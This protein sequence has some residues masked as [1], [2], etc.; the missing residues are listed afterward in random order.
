MHRKHN[1]KAPCHATIKSTMHQTYLQSIIYGK[2]TKNQKLHVQYQD[3]KNYKHHVQQALRTM[4][5]VH[6]KHWR[7]Q[8]P[9]A[10]CYLSHH[11]AET[12][13]F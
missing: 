10:P 11:V 3:L 9:Y 8:E 2:P 13:E 5:I 1:Y 4:N 7:H 12:P 6:G